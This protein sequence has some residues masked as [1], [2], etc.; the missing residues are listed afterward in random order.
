M[1]SGNGVTDKGQSFAAADAL[2]RPDTPG[3]AVAPRTSPLT[4]IH[5]LSGISNM[6]SSSRSPHLL[7]LIAVRNKDGGGASA[8]T[9]TAAH[10]RL[11][12]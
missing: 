4:S 3:S 9:G 6:P 1:I 12:Y 5:P 7:P 10:C 2:R 8:A 11:S